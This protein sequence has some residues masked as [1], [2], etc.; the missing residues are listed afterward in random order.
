[1]TQDE[2]ISLINTKKQCDQ[3]GRF[4]KV[5]GNK[6]PCKSSPNTEQHFKPFVKYGTFNVKLMWL[7][8]GQVL[9]KIGL[10]L[11]QHL[12]TLT[13]SQLRPATDGCELENLAIFFASTYNLQICIDLRPV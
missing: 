5:L 11:L 6:V 7:L 9:V 12:V 2:S 1:M 4:L 3:I 8:F 13:V 10:L